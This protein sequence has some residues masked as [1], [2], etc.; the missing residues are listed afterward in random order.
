MTWLR[1]LV[2][3]EHDPARGPSV[4]VL[5]MC[6]SGGF[7]LATAFN[8]KVGAAVLGHPA[9]PL[10]VWFDRLPDLG[11]SPDELDVLRRRLGD[12]ACLRTVRYAWDLK[13]P[14][15]RRDRLVCEFP[16]IE[17]VEIETRN[18]NRHSV[19]GEALDANGDSSRDQE[20]RTA[21]TDTIKFLERELGWAG[22]D[23]RDVLEGADS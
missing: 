7:A 13:S 19:F 14:A 16:A 21:L 15:A 3:A 9:L 12:G 22:G 23:G 11:I 17:H 6:F 8:P 4:G 5:G 10:P 20:L 2:D 1:A 18:P